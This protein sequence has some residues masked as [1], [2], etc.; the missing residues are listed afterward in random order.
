MDVAQKAT[1]IVRQET[2]VSRQD[3][4]RLFGHRSF[5]VWYTGLPASGKSTVAVHLEKKLHDFGLHTYILD[6]DNVRHGLNKDLGFSPEDREENIR[7]LAEVAKLLRD[8]GVIN[9]T[10]FIS[11]YRRE[12]DFARSLAGDDD[13]IE[14]FVDCPLE[15]CEERDPKGMYKKARAGIIKEYTGISAPYEV[16]PAPEV[17]IRTDLLDVEQCADAII[18][19]LRE[20]HL[21]PVE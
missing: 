12:R 18:A 7:R 4:E 17:H 1:N 2:N 9:L 19:A 3:R 15:I 20:R 21:I 5:T 11:P 13:F 10:A 8:T 14:V 6:G 16:P